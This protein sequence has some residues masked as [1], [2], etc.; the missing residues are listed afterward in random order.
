MTSS[1]F[2]TWNRGRALILNELLSTQ[3]TI[4][5]AGSKMLAINQLYEAYLLNLTG[6]FQAFCRDLHG[7][8]VQALTKSISPNDL[9][10]IIMIRL[11][12]GRKLDAGNPSKS[13]LGSDFSRFF[14]AADVLWGEVQTCIGSEQE[15][16]RLTND[17]LNTACDWRNAIAHA[18]ADQLRN[19]KQRHGKL[20]LKRIKD[21][22]KDMNTLARTLDVVMAAQIQ[23]LIG[24]PR[25]PW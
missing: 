1:A 23:K 22:R 11:Q 6:Q 16:K 8:S 9:R 5:K 21:W 13:A 18:N 7:L 15:F 4:R 2:K 25:P 12:D 17:S 14:P 19:L 24:A 20:T 10:S 3:T